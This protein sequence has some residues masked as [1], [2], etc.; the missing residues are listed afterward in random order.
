MVLKD[1]YCDAC[2]TS[3]YDV[4]VDSCDVVEIKCRCGSSLQVVA[5]G[6]V[7]KR[8]RV[9]DVDLDA[10]ARDTRITMVGASY[11]RPEGAPVVDNVTG[12]T[13][14]DAEKYT[15]QR[16]DERRQRMNDERRIKRNGPKLMFGATSRQ[17]A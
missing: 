10:C 4:V 13:Y 9:Y 2:G 12:E 16:R 1:F 15:T 3:A 17:G 11:D 5:N 14:H 8:V 7:K 6:G